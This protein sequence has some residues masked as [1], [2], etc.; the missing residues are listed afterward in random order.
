M[1]LN[2][3]IVSAYVA[4]RQGISAAISKMAFGSG[5]GVELNDDVSYANLFAPSYA[6]FVVEIPADRR[7]STES[8]TTTEL[9]SVELSKSL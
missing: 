7:N 9:S 5:L 6:D 2:G 4:D 1:M 8:V 3:T